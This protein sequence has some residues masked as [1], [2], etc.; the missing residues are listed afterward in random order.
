MN[1]MPLTAP[2]N[3]RYGLNRCTVMRCRSSQHI[4]T[5]SLWW[6]LQVTVYI[7]TISIR[8]LAR[9]LCKYWVMKINQAI[10]NLKL[11]IN[12]ENV[13]WSL[14]F[15]A[16]TLEP[17]IS[18]IYETMTIKTWGHLHNISWSSQPSLGYWW[19]RK[20]CQHDSVFFPRLW[21]PTS[22][23]LYHS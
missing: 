11:K 10:L 23:F 16:T 21:Q 9:L 4:K 19:Q 3:S 6:S 20:L 14:W 5:G 2:E 15:L 17:M 7:N 18:F 12:D 22:V 1:Q 8:L 13:F